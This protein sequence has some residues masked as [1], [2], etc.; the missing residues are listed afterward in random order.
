MSPLDETLSD[1]RGSGLTTGPHVMAHLRRE[2]VRRGIVTLAELQTIAAESWVT[3]AGAVIVRQRPG[4]AK[5]L[6][7]LTLEDE[8]GTGNALLSAECFERYRAV[9]HSA[10]LLILEGRLQRFDSV[11][12]L[13]IERLQA[14]DSVG[15]VPPS[16]DFR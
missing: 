13:R 12:H 15:I 14:L 5:G 8:T 3:T 10:G 7:F 1:Y 4:T 11:T 9:L 2:L 6:C 16:H